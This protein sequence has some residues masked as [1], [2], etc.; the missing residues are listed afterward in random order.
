MYYCENCRRTRSWPESYVT[1]FGPCE[2]CDRI[3]ACWDRPS[4]SLPDPQRDV[5]L[6]DLNFSRVNDAPR[7]TYRWVLGR[8]GKTQS[9]PPGMGWAPVKTLRV[10]DGVMVICE[11]RIEL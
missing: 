3:T 2:L 4:S 8:G 5:I 9:T 10:G 7:A 11:R 1:S 6:D